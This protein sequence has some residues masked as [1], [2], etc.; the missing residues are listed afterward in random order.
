MQLRTILIL[1]GVAEAVCAVFVIKWYLEDKK[2]GLK[3][4]LWRI[5]LVLIF[6]PVLFLLELL[7]KVFRRKKEGVQP[8]PYYLSDAAIRKLQ[9][10]GFTYRDKP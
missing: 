9:Q 7:S 1:V 10:Q 2:S 3:H 5:T 6:A 8:S 4:P